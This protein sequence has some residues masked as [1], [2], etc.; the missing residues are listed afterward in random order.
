MTRRIVVIS[1]GLRE[2]SSTSLLGER[3]AEATLTALAAR[4]SVAEVEV[5]ELRHHG[6]DI[7]QAM[8]SFAPEALRAV[9][10]RVAA[11]DG[12]IA[13]TPLFNTSYSGLFKSFFDVLPEGSLAGKPV[14]LGATGGTPRHSLALDYALRPMFA[15][16]HADV[17]T[18]GV[19]AATEDWGA[20]SDDVRPLTERITRAGESL[21]EAIAA[22]PAV[23][24]ADKFASTAS[25]E[26]MFSRLRSTDDDFENGL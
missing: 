15:Y 18:T 3:L 12:V 17:L 8:T 23:V 6:G 26:E 19:F 14:L 4:G 9:F 21:A 11:A 2:P 5:V 22:R 20:A 7:M 13:L 16:L 25:F 24:V 10:D 1:A